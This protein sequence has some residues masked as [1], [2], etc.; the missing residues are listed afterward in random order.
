MGEDVSIAELS[1]MVADTVG[2]DGRI[3]YD[4]TKLDG[5][6]RKLVDISRLSALGW[7]ARTP[8]RAGLALAYQ[9]FLAEGAER[10]KV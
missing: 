8:L 2:Y 5:T 3:V 6:P 10:R 1:R 4:A 7:R 9:H